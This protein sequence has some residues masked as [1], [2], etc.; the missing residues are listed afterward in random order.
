MLD[1]CEA[2]A[3]SHESVLHDVLSGVVIVRE[4]PREP[5]CTRIRIPVEPGELVVHPTRDPASRVDPC[6]IHTH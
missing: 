4:Q 1:G 2:R 3:Q 6:C 5:H